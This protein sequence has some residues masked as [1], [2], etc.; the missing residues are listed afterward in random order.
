M[1]FNDQIAL[2]DMITTD[3]LDSVAAATERVRVKDL[4]EKEFNQLPFGAIQ[5]DKTGRIVRYNDFESRLAGVPKEKAVGKNFFTEVAPCTNVKAF[6]GRFEEGVK[7]KSLHEKF[8]Y[9]FS[10]RQNPLDVTV[11]LFYCDITHSVW[12]FIRPV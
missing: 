4:S 6:H 10:F 12:V 11:T 7:R 2:A 8:R 1:P 3:S 9:H 5:L